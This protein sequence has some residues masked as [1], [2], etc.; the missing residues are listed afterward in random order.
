MAA[1]HPNS[2]LNHIRHLGTVHGLLL[3]LAKWPQL[4]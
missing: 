1:T 4:Q 2:F 3:Q